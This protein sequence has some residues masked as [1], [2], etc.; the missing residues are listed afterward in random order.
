MSFAEQIKK[1]EVYTTAYT[2]SG[3]IYG[4]EAEE[5]HKPLINALGSYLNFARVRI[6]V[7]IGRSLLYV[8]SP[9][10]IKAYIKPT[11]ENIESC[12]TKA[13]QLKAALKKSAFFEKNYEP[14]FNY[15]EEIIQLDGGNISKFIFWEKKDKSNEDVIR[16]AFVRCLYFDL[17][18]YFYFPNQKKYF[19]PIRL[20]VHLTNLVGANTDERTI[21]RLLESFNHPW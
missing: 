3:V 10:D 13:K 16:N 9:D 5:Q 20:L 6:M 7:S 21:T 2:G 15:L 1:C 8:S 4:S 14:I 17:R 19:I 18:R 12:V 11:I